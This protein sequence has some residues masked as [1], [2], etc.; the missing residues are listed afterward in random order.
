MTGEPNHLEL[1]V[2]DADAARRFYSQLFGWQ[3]S[4]STGPG[5]VRTSTLSIGIHD[6][7]PSSWFEVFFTVDDLDDALER[8]TRL[9]GTVDAQIHDD[10]DFGRWCE[11]ADD[12]G[13]RFGLRQ[14]VR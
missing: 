8:V 9:G 12:Q 2:A 3:P 1:G 5:D 11:C 10:G 14:P 4:G 13:T 6:Q 7:D